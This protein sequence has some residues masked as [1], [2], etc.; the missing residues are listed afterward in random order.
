M[1]T[2]HGPTYANP[3]TTPAPSDHLAY[4]KQVDSPATLFIVYAVVIGLTFLTVGLSEVGLGKAGLPVQLT[5]ASIQAAFV[6]YFFMHLKQSD[7]VVVLTALSSLFWMA[8]LF[9]LFM[10]DYM[11]RKILVGW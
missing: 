10:T 8:I 11:T 4:S 9:V 1:T 6:A 5:I 3:T 7:R 2:P